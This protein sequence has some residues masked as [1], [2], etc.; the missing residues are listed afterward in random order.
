[1]PENILP[2]FS[3]RSMLASCFIIKSLTILSLFCVWC[4]EVFWFH[5]FTCGC[6]A[7]PV[8][9]GR[10]CLFSIVESYFL[11][12]GLINPTF[13]GLF[14]GTPFCSI[15]LCACFCA[16][17]CCFDYYSFVAWHEVWKDYAS[18][19]VLFPPD[20]FGNFESFMVPYFKNYNFDCCVNFIVIDLNIS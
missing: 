8:P 4:E 3:S 11:C 17:P 10:G 18:S 15:D 7:F 16:I 20:C 6:P 1:M 14:L 12:H 13:V 19:F 5:S 9:L 2:V